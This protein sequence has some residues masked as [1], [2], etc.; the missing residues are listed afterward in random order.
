M[1]GGGRV[2]GFTAIPNAVLRDAS[3]PISARVLYGVIMSYA[4]GSRACTASADTLCEDA[5]I[6]RSAFFDGVAVL[7]DKGLLAIEKKHTKKGWRNIYIPVARGIEIP[8]EEDEEGRPESGQ[9]PGGRP[10]GRTGGRP[11]GRT[12]HVT[13][14]T[15][16]EEGHDVSLFSQKEEGQEITTT[17]SGA[18][19]QKMPEGFP[20]ELR[21]HARQAMKALRE[22]A[23]QHNAREVSALALGRTIMARPRKPLVKAAFDFAAWAADPPRPIRDVVASYRTWL[24]RERDLA[25]TEVLGPDGLPQTMRALPGKVHPATAQIARLRA[26]QAT[27]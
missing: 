24:D 27:L 4:W 15:N 8:D 7:R 25:G 9:T 16:G 12:T 18:A 19:K 11:A 26:M 17:S 2:K 3:I 6:G 14:K 10:A 13:K 1:P 20:D 5:G 22:V 21:P 23:E